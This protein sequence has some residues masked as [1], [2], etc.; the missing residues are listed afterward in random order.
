MFVG[1]RLFGPE[2]FG[3][4]REWAAFTVSVAL[5]VFHALIGRRLIKRHYQVGD[6]SN[7]SLSASQ[8][9]AVIVLVVGAGAFCTWLFC[10]GPGT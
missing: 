3:A 10:K 8:A 1:R 5:S 7:R 6:Q 4:H 9:I 2:W